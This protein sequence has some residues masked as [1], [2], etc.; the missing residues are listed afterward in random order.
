MKKIRDLYVY[1]ICIIQIV[2][3]FL[4]YL[5][6]DK[7]NV[8]TNFVYYI[9]SILFIFIQ[10]SFILKKYKMGKL[11]SILFIINALFIR[12]RIEV[13]D[14]FNFNFYLKYWFNHLEN[15]VVFYNLIGNIFVFIPLGTFIYFD[16]KNLFK[17]LLLML[18]MICTFE[19]LQAILKLGIFDI[20]DI[21]L[22]YLGVVFVILGVHIWEIKIKKKNN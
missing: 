9:I 16:Y 8:Y 12:R 20:V 2:F 14:Y 3:M 4:L 22:N 21:I 10:M 6:N 5:A 7:L 11:L 17:S 15:E 13:E 1:L 18:I 19:F